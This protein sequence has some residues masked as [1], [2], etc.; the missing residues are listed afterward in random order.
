MSHFTVGVIVNKLAEEEVHKMLAPYQENNMEDCPKE[1]LEFNSVT[2]EYKENYEND[3]RE[4]VRLEDGSLVSTYDDRFKVEIKDEKHPLGLTKY[5]IPENLEKVKVPF[6]VLYPTFEE[7]MEDYCEYTK[8]EETND[9]GYWENPNK[10][11]DW[12]EIGGRWNKLL[13]VKDSID[14]DKLGGPSWGNLDSEKKEAPEGY[15]WV[16]AC[17]LK[18]LELDKMIEGSYN[19]NL[20]FWELIVEGQEP[21]NEDEKED[22]K[23]SLYR[24]EYYTE[25]YSSKEEYAKWQSM[26]STFAL[27]NENGWYEKG[28]MGWFGFDTSTGDSERDFIKFFNNELKKPENQDKYLVIVDCHI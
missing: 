5:E 1:Y 9:Y 27:L 24:P 19:K 2:E 26:F 4:M 23:W 25:R 17:K 7:Y 22:V 8:D 12:Y 3:T 18:D 15:K 11:W 14:I 13:L 16:N 6:K 10:K 28:T 21:Q 20:R